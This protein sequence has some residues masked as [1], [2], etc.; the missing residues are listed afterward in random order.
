MRWEIDRLLGQTEGKECIRGSGSTGVNRSS[1]ACQNLRVMQ[2][3]LQIDHSEVMEK[4]MPRRLQVRI[5]ARSSFRTLGILRQKK[6]TETGS[7]S[8]SAKGIFVGDV[9]LPYFLSSLSSAMCACWLASD[10]AFKNA[11][12]LRGV[13]A[14]PERML[15][16]DMC[17]P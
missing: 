8:R 2:G 6:L 9:Y 14:F 1:R 11:S 7:R 17:L 5:S 15:R 16:N 10:I 12:A 13:D 4:P 3:R